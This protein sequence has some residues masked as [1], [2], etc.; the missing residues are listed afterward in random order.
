MQPRKWFDCGGI[1]H[2]GTRFNEAGAVQPRKSHSGD[3]EDEDKT[4]LLQ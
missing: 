3:D 1:G 4:E 2:D